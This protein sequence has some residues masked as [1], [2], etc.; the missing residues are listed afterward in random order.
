[1]ALV[2]RNRLAPLVAHFPF[3]I[4]FW[5]AINSLKRALTGLLRWFNVS[6][7]IGGN[8]IILT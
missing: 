1:M 8:V 3:A 4:I 5:L 7:L 2:K 6:N